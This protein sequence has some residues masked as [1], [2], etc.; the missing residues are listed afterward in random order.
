MD[1]LLGTVLLRPY[2]FAFLA[3]YLLGAWLQFGPRVTWV[4]LLLGYLTAFLSEYS[5][6]HLGFPYGDY[7]YIQTTRDRELW[8][9]GVPFMDSLSYVFLAACS[10]STALFLMSPLVRGD[11]GW[12][13]GDQTR[14]R[15]SRAVWILGG[16][17]ML[18]LDIVVDP[19]AL[20]GDKWFLGKIYGYSSPGAYF[21]IPMS[22]FA[23][24]LLVGLCMTRLFQLL[25]TKWGTAQ[26]G[27]E[28]LGISAAMAWGPLLYL[29]ILLFNLAVS[30]AIGETCL[31]TAS[32]F[33]SGTF[34]LM[35]LSWTAYKI[36]HPKKHL[37]PPPS[38][39]QS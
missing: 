18:L 36:G 11:K 6:I 30:F 28:V 23:G 31:A 10:Y 13:L 1:L 22:N 19:V 15:R 29:S 25:E 38:S 17:L 12:E 32:S 39:L 35:A 37:P 26:R 24:W 9:M 21:G 33:I 2:V 4:F 34:A 27:L 5:S 8:V 16:F 3:C 7:F 20:Q 14:A